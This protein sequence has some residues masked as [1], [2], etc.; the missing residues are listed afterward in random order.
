MNIALRITLFALLTS[1]NLACHEEATQQEQYDA[2]LVLWHALRG[3]DQVHLRKDLTRFEHK[4]GLK[5]LALQLPH[6]A[7]AN[8][9]QVS[10]PR[11]NG[12]D[13]F[14]GPHDRVGD[15]A[16]AGHI[17]ALSYWVKPEA[18]LKFMAS[19]LEAF[20]YKQQ[21][22]GLPLSCKALALFYNPQ[23]IP[24]APETIAELIQQAQQFQ[25]Q[26][27]SNRGEQSWGLAY[28]E[29]DSLYFHAPWLHAFG[30]QVI[31]RGQLNLNHTAMHKSVALVK[32]LRDQGLIP[33]EIDGALASELFRRGKL[34]FLINGPW[35]M[36]ELADFDSERWAVALLPSLKKT[37]TQNP[38]PQVM[39]PYL[40]VE[41]VMVSAY[42]KQSQKAWR[43]AQFLASPQLAIHRQDRGELIA[44]QDQSL[45]DGRKDDQVDSSSSKP[46]SKQK[47]WQAIFQAQVK[48]SI[49][50]SN[51]PQMKG[52]WTPV[53][54][55]LGQSILYDADIKK[56]FAE[57]EKAVSKQV[58]QSQKETQDD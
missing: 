24:Q 49:P 15:W 41:G 4:T 39:R 25:A 50:L 14:I 3:M 54:R 6:Q 46:N 7:F 32:K 30:A 34:A 18:Y 2:P 22:Y 29:L 23:V 56:S 35:F 28:P 20:T 38:D 9:L 47:K 10:I 5:V 19:P 51:D 8:K 37:S 13:V 55:A 16:E 27:K 58:Q 42:S 17:E 36:S 11:G 45:S 33:P 44:Y 57:A 48:S 43:L 26:T 52:L 40:S 31:E 53:K 12:P 1:F 21:L